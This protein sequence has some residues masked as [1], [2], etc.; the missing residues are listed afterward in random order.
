MALIRTFSPFH[1]IFLPPPRPLDI[2]P[3][4][5]F[6]SE[7][8]FLD[9]LP[10]VGHASKRCRPVRQLP[11]M[12]SFF[13][14]QKACLFM[15]EYWCMVPMI[16]KQKVYYKHTQ[17]HS[18]FNGEFTFLKKI[19]LYDPGISKS[20]KEL[21]SYE[22]QGSLMRNIVHRRLFPLH[23]CF[24]RDISEHVRIKHNVKIS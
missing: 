23:V 4:A 19:P 15:L 10:I 13:L 24:G 5:E 8:P 20:G 3:G 7:L 14:F 11:G 17:I 21:G 16:P 2:K 12:L 9:S 1:F 18:R 22:Q 6:V